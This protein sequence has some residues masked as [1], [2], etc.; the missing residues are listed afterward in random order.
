MATQEDIERQKEL[1][2]LKQEQLNLEDK[3]NESLEYASIAFKN[4]VDE[5]RGGNNQL[6]IAEQLQKSRVS[7]LTKSSN[8]ARQLLEVAKGESTLSRKQLENIRSK[9]KAEQDNLKRILQ[10]SDGR[11]VVGRQIKQEIADLE[12]IL[13]KQ[14]QIENTIEDTNKA[15]GP[16]PAI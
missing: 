12:A 7:S 16:A 6:K 9:T 15:I 3:S 14:T 10:Q 2:R 8:L 4:I 5:I 1:N 11:T 13:N